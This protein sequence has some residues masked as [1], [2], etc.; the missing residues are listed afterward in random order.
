MII[1]NIYGSLTQQLGQ[2]AFGMEC[3]ARLGT[4][5]KLDTGTISQPLLLTL[6]AME[7]ELATDEEIAAAKHTASVVENTLLF[8]PNIWNRIQDG[9]YLDGI[10]HDFGYS[11]TALTAL[12]ASITH[13]NA[14]STHLH[15]LLLAVRDKESVSLDLR[16]GSEPSL[17]DF[18]ARAITEIRARV[19]TAHLFILCDDPAVPKQLLPAGAPHT[20]V[21]P[22]MLMGE[23][24]TL[25]LM[26]ACKHHIA[27]YNSTSC[28][29]ARLSS[30]AG[31]GVVVPQQAFD[32]RDT[33]LRERFGPITQPVWPA[34]WYAL[35]TL[36]N[37]PRA[38]YL[39]IDGGRNTGPR[40]RVV[41][42]CYY[43]EFNV[44]GFIFKNS[45][46]VGHDLLKPWSD[47]HAYGQA[48][49]I[50]FITYD[51]VASIDEVDAVIFMDRPRVGNP[52]PDQLMAADIAKYLLI[53]ECEVIKPDNW[54][55]GYHHNFTRVFTWNDTLVDGDRYIKINFAID[56]ESP[57][58][59]STLKSA[60]GQR[61]LVT[62]IAGAKL[63]QHP[64]E[65]YS[66][67]IR[68]IRW[69]ESS[70][71]DDF[72]LYG[73]GWNREMFP[74][75]KGKVDD[76]LATYARYR[77]AIC[78]ENAANYPGYISEKML[79]CFRAG[80]VPVYG[81]APNIARWIPSD[82]YID[83]SQFATYDDL[84][85]HLRSMDEATHGAYLD[86]IAHYLASP[87]AYPF[88]IECFIRTVTHF[89]AWD[90]QQRRQVPVESSIGQHLV[91]QIDTL[92]IL[93]KN[94]SETSPNT[95]DDSA[96]TIPH[97]KGDTQLERIEE[98]ERP[99]LVV[100][101]GYGY[102]LPV[103]RRA[104]A[105]WQFYISH[106]P[107]FK[108]IFVRETE[109][110]ARGEVVS[111]GYDLLVGIG[112]D[113]QGAEQGYAT[114]GVWSP[115]ENSR[116]IFRQMAVYDYLLR[117]HSK[118]FFLYQTTVTS[119]VDFRALN[120]ILMQMPT[121]GCYAGTTGR[122][123]APAELNGLTFVS[124]ANSLFSRDV[125]ELMR[126]RYDPSHPHAALPNDVWQALVLQDIPR[127]PLPSFNFVKPRAPRAD[128]GAIFA[129]AQRL[130]HD[131][132]FHFRIKTTSA[133]AGQG[134]REDVDPWIM[135]KAMEA[136]LSTDLIPTAAFELR[137]RFSRFIDGGAGAPLGAFGE[138]SFYGG[139]RDFPLNDTEAQEP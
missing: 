62:M 82:C 41:V 48:H 9:A 114:Q 77:F 72:D 7:M 50:D 29:A 4:R 76:K 71:I 102:E 128:A 104:R 121:T 12:A 52:I 100:Y 6:L 3:A 67:R 137:K 91:Q 10:W 138:V 94:A 98:T 123:T 90:V 133:E 61:K 135:L 132:H 130:L 93:L 16:H 11:S 27:T 56:P 117:T 73:M 53:Y 28:W 97:S 33:A 57:Y 103:Y 25:Q 85:Q 113:F 5:L 30:S 1:V 26:L 88:S 8:D 47:L 66:H 127:L 86:R 81:G 68:A 54:D 20:L 24:E 75:Y 18:F 92:G 110:L 64:N 46:S 69:F 119:V 31:G 59:F 2:Y 125:L 42:W 122:L 23:S 70:A 37:K 17:V 96:S 89:V 35:P 115:T 78:Y 118:P 51:Q 79:D 14:P 19:P 15:T 105:L 80:V 84:H 112:S 74:S 139:P 120:N 13:H 131:G 116:V 129:L 136:V 101:I 44:D 99:E 36:C 43:E 109:K 95:E 40:L 49:G 58:D 134:K 107:G 126:N 108:T 45:V 83:I 60:F 111:D 87:E 124:G 106:F 55:R 32:V 22:D 38:T 65:L 39:D 34:S 21:T 63:S